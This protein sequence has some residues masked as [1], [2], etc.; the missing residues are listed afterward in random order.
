MLALQDLLAPLSARHRIA[1]EWFQRHAGTEQP[2]PDILS[3]PEG[4]TFLATRAKGIYKPGWS[5]YALSARQVLK[6][7]YPEKGPH[8]RQDGT[9]SYGYFQ[10]N[11]DP[12]ARDSEYTNQGLMLC[13]ENAVPV[14]VMRQTSPKPAVRYQ[15]LGLALVAG[16]DGGYFFFEGFAPNGLARPGGT[17]TEIELLAAEQQRLAAESHSF[18]PV[19]IID[20]RQRVLAQIVRRRGQQE[21]R[22]RLLVAYGRRCAI[23]GCDAVEA[24]E[25][26]HIVPYQ[27]DETNSTQNGLLL[28]ADVHVLFDLGLIGINPG[29]MRVVISARLNSTVYRDFVGLYLRKAAA[30][31]D[32]PSTSALRQHFV[33]A[34]L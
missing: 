8:L 20:S 9:W 32:W 26:A 14:G 15:I 30:P 29:A 11:D 21:F 25:A 6:S 23:T 12:E 24:L 31:K 13:W 27:G 3:T 22:E 2:W 18:D 28:R 4:P 19:G 10:E 34:G 1:L 17:N 5:K 16:W 33:W 7:R